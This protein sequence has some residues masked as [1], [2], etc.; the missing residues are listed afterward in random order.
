MTPTRY[1]LEVEAVQITP[2]NAE[3]AAAWV[4]ARVAVNRDNFGDPV[5]IVPPLKGAK[6]PFPRS[7]YVEDYIMRTPDGQFHVKRELEMQGFTPV[8]G[9]PT[10]R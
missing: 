1:R 8:P 10:G 7:A 6:F 9:T 4:G 5:L 2:D 3:E